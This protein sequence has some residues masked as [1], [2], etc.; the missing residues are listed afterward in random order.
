M[1]IKSAEF[2]ISNTDYRLC[3]KEFLPEYAFIGRSNVGKSSY[4][5]MDLISSEILDISISCSSAEISFSLITNLVLWL[6]KQS[7]NE[8]SN[9]ADLLFAND[10]IYYFTSFQYS[11]FNKNAMNEKT[12]K[13]SIT[14]K[15]I[16]YLSN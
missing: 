15:P 4:G 5:L 14:Q 7:G 3:P 2:V 8:K 13:K 12:P 1:K 6:C 10:V 16:L 9:I 11:L